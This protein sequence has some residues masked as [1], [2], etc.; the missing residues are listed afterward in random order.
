MATQR[1]IVYFDSA[2]YLSRAAAAWR[3]WIFANRRFVH[4]HHYSAHG[5]RVFQVSVSGSR[6]L[7]SNLTGRQIQNEKRCELVDLLLP[8][9]SCAD[10]FG[11]ADEKF[12]LRSL[13]LHLSSRNFS[14]PVFGHVTSVSDRQPLATRSG[15]RRL[16]ER[17]ILLPLTTISGHFCLKELHMCRDRVLMVS[18]RFYTIDCF[19]VISTYAVNALEEHRFSRFYVNNL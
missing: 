9:L 15:C 3:Q 14:L 18:G 13:P 11:R 5:K 19:G 1:Q 12:S 8:L 7:L 4:H 2:D 16:R 17:S 6:P 10:G